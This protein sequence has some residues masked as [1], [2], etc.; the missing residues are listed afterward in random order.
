MPSSPTAPPTALLL[1]AHDVTLAA[2][3]LPKHSRHAPII[4]CL[5]WPFLLPGRRKVLP[6]AICVANFLI[7]AKSSFQCQ[8]FNGDDF[9]GLVQ[10]YNLVSPVASS[11]AFFSSLTLAFW[12]YFYYHISKLLFELCKILTVKGGIGAL[13]LIGGNAVRPGADKIHTTGMVGLVPSRSL[14]NSKIGIGKKEEIIW[15]NM[16]LQRKKIISKLM[17]RLSLELMLEGF[18]TGLSNTGHF[19]MCVIL[20]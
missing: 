9:D 20:G 15:T 5:F 4:R 16:V 7:S 13:C 8:P 2:W 11:L 6:S 18:R 1:L 10:I 3:L 17:L 19:S 12:L 14:Y